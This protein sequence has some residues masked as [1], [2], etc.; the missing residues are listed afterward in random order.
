LLDGIP[1]LGASQ[2]Q[3][4]RRCFAHEGI[5]PG[6]RRAF[7]VYLACRNRPVH[8]V[9]FPSLRDV[10]QD[11][12]RNFKGMPTEPEELGHCWPRGNACCASCSKAWMPTSADSCFRSSPI[13]RNGR[14]WG[15]RIWNISPSIR[16]KLLHNLERLQKTN[17]RKFAEQAEALARL[18]T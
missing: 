7:V 8:E 17:A 9:L 16:W 4:E 5:T 18:L 3:V 15:W 10:S 1:G 12:E 14:C 13:S 2:K 6:I 11:Y